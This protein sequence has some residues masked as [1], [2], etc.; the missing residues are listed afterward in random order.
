MF[1]SECVL[2]LIEENILEKRAILLQSLP[3][4]SASNCSRSFKK[5][6]SQG[7]DLAR[8][9]EDVKAFRKAF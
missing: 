8:M 5:S 7:G 9:L 3:P 4:S 1:A 6:I 2:K